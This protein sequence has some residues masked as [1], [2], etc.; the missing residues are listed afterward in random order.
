MNQRVDS[1]L[2]LTA[3]VLLG[4]VFVASGT[5]KAAAPAEEFALVIESYGLVSSRDLILVMSAFLPWLEVVFGY[6]LLFGFLTRLSAAAIGGMVASFATAI[7][8]TILKG[9]RL[10]NCGCFGFGFTP[11]PHQELAMNGLYAVCA[12]QAL[13]R[14]AGRLSLDAWCKTG[15]PTGRT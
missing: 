15:G 14:G 6:A 3:R 2:G 7:L 12:V 1:W 9:I 10:P 5:L 8:Y 11:T 4:L 13:R